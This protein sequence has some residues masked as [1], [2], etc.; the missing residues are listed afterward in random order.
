MAPAA[1][2]DAFEDLAVAG[3]VGLEGFGVG[4][5]EVAGSDGVDLDALGRPLVGEGLGELGDSALAGGVGGD[6][7]AALEAEERGDVD[8]LAGCLR[9]IMSRAASCESWKTLVRL[10]WMTC[11]QSSSGSVFGG[12]AD[13]WC[14][15]C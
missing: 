3:L 1:G 5:G 7:D 8:D 10:T 4:G 15:R 11:S 9:G 6:A 2:G 14:R 13:E 12:V